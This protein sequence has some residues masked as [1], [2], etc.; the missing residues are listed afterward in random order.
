[1][2][3]TDQ[4]RTDTICLFDVD[5]TIT[6]PR[7]LI[8]EDMDQFLQ[9]L[10][11]KCLIGLVGGSNIVKIAEQIGG[12]NAIQKY[13]YVF[14]ENGLVAYKQ[15]QLVFEESIQKHVG[16]D[17]LQSFIN[18]CLNY[19][20]QIILPVKRGTFIE[21]RNGLINISPIGR[22]CSTEERNE[23]EKYDVKHE[24]RS[25]M[26]Q[27][28]KDKF[29]HLNLTYAIGGQISFDVFPQGWDK[30]YS[31]KHLEKDSISNVYFFGDKT[32]EVS[33]VLCFCL[34]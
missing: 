26:I 20:S 13:D 29:A 24:I 11:Q 18:F 31:L 33:R 21:F 27:Q 9:K 7:Q 3:N 25:T 6:M 4:R 17:N 16:E 12:M 23:F 14:A 15:G 10:K 5:G 1:M 28:L 30:T 2:T 8:T 19:L 22:N 32:F 34:S